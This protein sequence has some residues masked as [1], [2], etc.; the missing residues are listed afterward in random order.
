VPGSLYIVATPIGNLEDVTLRA[1]RILREAD[2]V[3]AEDT[4]HTRKLL[5]HY[6]IK[7]PLTAYHQH[8][9]PGVV[10]GLIRRIRD[11]GQSIAF[12]TDAGTPGV[13]DPGP[14]LVA[15]AIAAG[16]PVVP[17]PGP[18]AALSALVGSGLPAARWAFEG[19]LPRTRSS[20]LAKL[21]ALAAEPRT[22]IFYEAGNRTVD[23]LREMAAA[24][25]AD[26]PA[27]VGRELTKKHEEFVRGPISI[28]LAHYT[29]EA[30]RGEVTIVIAGRDAATIPEPD[31]AAPTLAEALA[32]ALARGM[33]ERDA[34]REVSTVLGLSRREVYAAMLDAKHA[35]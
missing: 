30:P 24:F 25:G 32:A 15:A 22:L 12:V 34:V 27:A 8:S 17:I 14:E 26:R 11:D 28:V 21:A 35:S 4:R 16:V 33:S 29:N 6:E 3:A 2:L 13:S 31:A 9:D 7:T 5:S 10:E 1:L 23:T 20:R 18:S 19:F